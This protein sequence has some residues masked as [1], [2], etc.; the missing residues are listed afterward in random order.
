M[1]MPEY[2]KSEFVTLTQDVVNPKPDRRRKHIVAAPIWKKGTRIEVATSLWTEERGDRELGIGSMFDELD[3]EILQYESKSWYFP[4]YSFNS[5]TDEQIEALRPHIE[6]DESDEAWF[7]T[8]EINSDYSKARILERMVRSG[9]NPDRMITRDQIAQTWEKMR[10][11]DEAS[12]ENTLRDA[13][14]KAE[15]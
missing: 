13:W 12:I 8:E 6:G 1:A 3:V 11:E 2:I 10:Y 5:L 4:G 7:L 15:E 14:D 9:H